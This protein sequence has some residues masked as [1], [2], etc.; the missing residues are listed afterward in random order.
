MPIRCGLQKGLQKGLHQGLHQGLTLAAIGVIAIAGALVLSPPDGRARQALPAAV[1]LDAHAA[2]PEGP[3][4]WLGAWHYAEMGADRISRLGPEGTKRTV[5][6]QPGCGPTAIAPYRDGLLALCHFS[7]ALVAFDS[8]GRETARFRATP[9]GRRLRNPN[10]ASADGRGGVYLSDPGAFS[11]E[12][13]AEGVIFHLSAA[14]Q[15]KPVAS[16]LWYP[17]GVHVDVASG[18]L[19]VSE[20]LAGK[21]WRFRIGPNGA[22]AERTLIADLRSHLTPGG[23]AEAGPDGLEIGPDGRLYVALYGEGK[24]LALDLGQ[25]PTRIEALP[26]PTVYVANLAFSPAGEAIALGPVDNLN[27]PF[28]G[29]VAVLASPAAPVSG[30]PR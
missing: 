10:D 7:G 8:A 15:L 24:V 26:A 6:Q 13:A 22:L 3:L 28:P 5:F 16:G 29:V 30:P 18:Q 2:Y 21:V 1:T 27:P 14:G 4:H 9:N 19:Y 11:R 23:Y 20:H 12:I 17:N 25:S